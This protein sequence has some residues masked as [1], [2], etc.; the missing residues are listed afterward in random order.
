VALAVWSPVSP[1]RQNQSVFLFFETIR[2]GL[3]LIF[4]VEKLDFA[5]LS[6]HGFPSISLG[7][8]YWMVEG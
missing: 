6:L 1:V 8:F 7:S 4:G 5:K 2:Q 3:G